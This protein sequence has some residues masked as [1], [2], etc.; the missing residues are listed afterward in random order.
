MKRLWIV[1][2]IVAVILAASGLSLWHLGAVSQRMDASLQELSE[3]VEARDD[4]RLQALTAA[5]LEEWEQD[6]HLMMR[7]IH[8]DELDAINGC[9]ARL[10]ALARYG[11]YP[12]LAAE[13]DRMRHLV[14]H[15]W[16]SEAPS[17]RNIF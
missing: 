5:F 14:R 8:H 11:D 12:E 13:L 17:L 7:Y 1:F 9:A 2:G 4:A 15:I 10:P 16:E 3:A 6:E